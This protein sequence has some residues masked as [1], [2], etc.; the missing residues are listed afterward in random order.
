M[1][2]EHETTNTTCQKKMWFEILFF[3]TK[4]DRVMRTQNF[5]QNTNK[6]NL[7]KLS[8]VIRPLPGLIGGYVIRP[9]TRNEILGE[10][11]IDVGIGRRK[12]CDT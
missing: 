4:W 5:L 7:K 3:F 6:K 1:N 2:V 11:L 12:Q 10:A 9:P 8:V